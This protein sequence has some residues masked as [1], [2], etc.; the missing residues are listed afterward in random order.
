MTLGG[1]CSKTCK[2]LVNLEMQ[3][4]LLD[5]LFLF[6]DEIP[7]LIVYY[8]TR[9]QGC[10]ARRIA[11]LRPQAKGL[12]W[13]LYVHAHMSSIILSMREFHPL[14]ISLKVLPALLGG[15][16]LSS[17]KGRRIV[18]ILLCLKY[19]LKPELGSGLPGRWRL[20]PTLLGSR[21][22]RR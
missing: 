12:H 3:G 13:V 5:S 15:Y 17:T 7:S 8:W 20:R 9:E 1:K 4:I 21:V 14:T 6:M 10:I 22:T 16:V 2:R 11:I 19:D 18:R